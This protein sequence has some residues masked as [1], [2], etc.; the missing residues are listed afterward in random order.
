MNAPVTDQF[1]VLVLHL[2]IYGVPVLLLALN[3]AE[4]VS[5]FYGY[6]GFM[7]VFTQLFAVLYS[8]HVNIGGNNLTITGGNIAYSSLILITMTILFITRDASIIKNFILI[9]IILNVFLFF[10]YLLLG[11]LLSDPLTTNIFN[12]S[13]GLFSTTIAINSISS[14]VYVVETMILFLGL[15]KAKQATT[16]LAFIIPIAACLFTGILCLDGFLFPFL[17][18]FFEPV[19]GQFIVGG[20]IGKLV[21]GIGF[22]PVLIAFCLIYNRLFARYVQTTIHVRDMLLPSGNKLLKRLSETQSKLAA[23]ERNYLAAYKEATLLRQMFTHDIANIVQVISLALQLGQAGDKVNV[24]DRVYRDIQA[25]VEKATKLIENVKKETQVQERLAEFG[26]KDVEATINSVAEEARA[27]YLDRIEIEIHAV[28]EPV[29]VRTNDML[30]DI[31]RNIITNAVRYN[32]SKIP[33]ID[34]RVSIEKSTGG[35]DKIKIEFMDN[36][37]GIPDDR[38]AIIFQ[39]GHQ[40]KKGGKGMGFGLSLVTKALELFG[41]DIHVEDKVPGDPSRGS[42]FVIT[43]P[44]YVE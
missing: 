14:F 27:E 38:K 9:Q 44:R 6:F 7:F 1:A 20:I 30:D 10:L 15:E 5:F 40:D 23:S 8:I 12:I 25:Q 34:I 37:T 28:E 24:N 21:L 33:R 2:V 43:L 4:R 41:G 18:M 16:R 31:L 39:E 17:V 29:K 19:F 22:S 42:N 11:F 35:K 3:R 26:I 36:G 32:E 13:P